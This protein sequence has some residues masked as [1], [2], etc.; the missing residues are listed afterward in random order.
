MNIITSQGD[1]QKTDKNKKPLD[2]KFSFICSI[3]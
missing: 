2:F 1:L 3:K